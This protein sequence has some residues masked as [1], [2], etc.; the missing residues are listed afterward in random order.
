MTNVSNN[1]EKKSDEQFIIMQTIIEANKQEMISNKQDSNEKMTKFTEEFEAM[2]AAII[3]L[4]S[5]SKYLPTK[6]N[7]PKPPHPTT[8][9]PANR[10]APPLDGGQSTKKC[11][12]WTLKYEISSP[13]FYEL[14]I[15]TELKGNTA[16]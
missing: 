10:R 3:Y 15:K 4:I 8:V 1:M 2:I 13:I 5:T 14:F 11:G 7:S 9:V 12:M 6:K 16:S